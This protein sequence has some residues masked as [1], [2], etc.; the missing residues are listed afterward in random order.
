MLHKAHLHTLSTNLKIL[1]TKSKKHLK[2]K[3]KKMPKNS[4]LAFI[5]LTE[6]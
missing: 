5:C 6:N 2:K 1:K 4:K 3:N